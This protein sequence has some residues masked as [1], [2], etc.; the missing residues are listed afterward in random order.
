[1]ANIMAHSSHSPSPMPGTPERDSSPTPFQSQANSIT[2]PDNVLHLQEEMNEAKVH[3]LNIRALVDAHQQRIISE[4]KVAHYKNE[5]K[6]SEAIRE[7]K[8]HYAAALSDAESA[9]GTAMRKVEAAHSAFTSEVEAKHATAIRKAEAASV[10]QALKL[11]QV[12]QET[13][14]NVEDEALEV[15]KHACQSF[16]WA[17]GVA[18]QACPNEALGKLMYPIHLLTGNM[19]LTSLLMAASPLT[20]RLRDPI[21]S[22]CCPRRSATVTHSPRAK[23]QHLPGHEVE[24]DCPREPPL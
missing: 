3:L 12:H 19:S 24:P 23:L 11:Q 18:L 6:T 1:M 7:V 20:I 13:M 8:A 4:M 15:E 14:H 16:L 17:C 9:Y 2:L 5:I 22:P 10:V 21:P